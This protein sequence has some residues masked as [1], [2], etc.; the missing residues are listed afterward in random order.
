MNT[1]TA[2]E[3][4]ACSPT[5]FDDAINRGIHQACPGLRDLRKLLS[6]HVND[7]QIL[8]ENGRPARYRV[9]LQVTFMQDGEGPPGT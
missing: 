8:L 3:V 5:G 6:T 1:A 4:S 9:S 2:V 7:Q